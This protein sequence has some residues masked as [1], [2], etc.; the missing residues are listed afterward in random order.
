MH[1]SWQNLD[2]RILGLGQTG[3]SCLRWAQREGLRPQAFDT[4]AQLATVR[5]WVEEFP[6]CDLHFGELPEDAL[7]G[8]DLVLVSPGLPPTLAAL[9][10]AQADGIALWSD[11]ELFG[12]LAG[13]PIAAIT[14]SN[15]KSTVTTLLG[16]MARAAGIEVAVGGNLGTPALDLLPAENSPAPALYVLELSSFQLH[17]CSDFR[18]QVAAILNLSPDHLDWHGDMD[19]YLAAKAR[20]F[21]AMGE[22]DTVVLNAEDP[23]LQTL[24][25]RVP[26]G[27]RL[28]TFGHSPAADAWAD[29]QAL[30]WPPAASL[31]VDELRLPGAH[32]RENVLAAAL[33]ASALDLSQAAIRQAAKDFRGL[34]HR[35]QW[36]ARVDGVDYYDDSKGTNLGA[37]L[38]AIEALSG[39]LVLILGGDAKGTDLSPLRAALQGQRGAVLLGK[40]AESLE[41]ILVGA[42]PIRRIREG[43]M[44]AAV[45]AAATMAQPGDQVLLSPACASLDMFQDY[46][47]RGRQFAAAV[48][49]MLREVTP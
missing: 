23:A 12:R 43:G 36:V 15:G 48:Q 39:P 20:I 21:R 7:L 41:N 22:G 26:A 32:N 11:I 44:A 6:G 4:R 30:H 27:V 29:A 25:P 16:E 9:R 8:A 2:I 24:P 38:R 34:P 10:R 49:T 5:P 42:L 33:M 28:R 40:D 35:L 18:P 45:Q 14:G 37:S 46:R 3:L 19:A 1:T 17:Y 47:D 31:A 13:A